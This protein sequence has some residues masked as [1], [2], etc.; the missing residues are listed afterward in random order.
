[1]FLE[2]VDDE[3]CFIKTETWKFDPK[4]IVGFVVLIKH[5]DEVIIINIIL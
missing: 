3:R 4:V 2:E 5:T 1:M